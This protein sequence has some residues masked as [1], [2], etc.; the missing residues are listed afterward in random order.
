MD[1]LRIAKTQSVPVP[2]DREIDR[3]YR[4]VPPTQK[5]WAEMIAAIMAAEDRHAE[6]PTARL[7]RIIGAMNVAL[8]AMTDAMMDDLPSL[9]LQD[10]E[11]KGE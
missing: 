3:Q 6:R 4:R 8:D 5:D 2:P 7:A 1:L 11:T 9:Q 10:S